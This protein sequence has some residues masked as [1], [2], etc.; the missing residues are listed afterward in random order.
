ME[1]IFVR[2]GLLAGKPARCPSDRIAIDLRIKAIGE[3]AGVPPGTYEEQEAY[4]LSVARAAGLDGWHLDRLF[5]NVKDE[6][7]A[8]ICRGHEALKP[9]VEG[10]MALYEYPAYD[11]S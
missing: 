6:V 5:Y 1:S 7:L 3:P 8:A 10:S 11:M 4:Y 2:L 9:I